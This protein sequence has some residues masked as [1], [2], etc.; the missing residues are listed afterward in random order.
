L[1]VPYFLLF[2]PEGQELTLFRHD[3]KKYVSVTANESGRCSI[4]ELNLEVALQDGWA[5]FWFEGKLLPLP[6][7]LQRELE[8]T[9]KELSKAR[10]E[11]RRA[12]QE[13]A[14][15]QQQ[16]SLAVQEADRE[17]REKEKLLAQLRELGIEPRG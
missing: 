4:A 16:K 8:L 10:Q 12:Q 11:A 5:R 6:A 3:G 17:R 7:D 13:A 2:Y 9:R 15:A 14:Q 1:K